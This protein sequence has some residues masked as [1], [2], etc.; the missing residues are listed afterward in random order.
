MQ[1]ITKF[2]TCVVAA[3]ALV[4]VGLN[5]GCTASMYSEE[6]HVQRV[7]ERAEERGVGEESEETGL[8]A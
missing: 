5:N 2:F 4:S 3:A 7:S 6:Q 1:T 8:E